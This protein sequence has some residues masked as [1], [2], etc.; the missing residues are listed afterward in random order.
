M[1]KSRSNPGSNIE[2]VLLPALFSNRLTWKDSV[3][4]GIDAP[5]NE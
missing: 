2:P 5:V 3:P 1:V 4:S